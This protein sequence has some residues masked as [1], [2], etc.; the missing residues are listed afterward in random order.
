MST[1]LDKTIIKQNIIAHL[2]EG[3]SLYAIARLNGYPSYQTVIKWADKDEQFAK[4]LITARIAGGYV[5]ADRA[6]ALVDTLIDSK[7]YLKESKYLAPMLQQLRWNAERTAR[8]TYGQQLEVKHT[9]TVNIRTSFLISRTK[10][11][12]LDG[13]IIDLDASMVPA[14]LGDAQTGEGDGEAGEQDHAQTGD[15]DD[16]WMG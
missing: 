15:G 11:S 2:G 1:A 7:E 14:Q 6:N 16:D 8:V 5:S 10:Q 9:G 13:E 3:K 12:V 4:V